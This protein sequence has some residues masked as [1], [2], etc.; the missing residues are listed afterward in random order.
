MTA[1]VGKVGEEI[2]LE[3]VVVGSDCTSSSIQVP[4]QV[5]IDIE[6]E[7]LKVVGSVR[8]ECELQSSASP[9]KKQKKSH[10]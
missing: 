8:E 3:G 6:E 5:A 2:K 7:E 10:I 1:S 4:N 9:R